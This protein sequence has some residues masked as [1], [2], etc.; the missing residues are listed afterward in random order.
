[1]RRD[2]S[3]IARG[4]EVDARSVG[5]CGERGHTHASHCHFECHPCECCSW[6]AH[7]IV[8]VHHRNKWIDD[9]PVNWM[10]DHT[11]DKPVPLGQRAEQVQYVV[12][13]EVAI[14]GWVELRPLPWTECILV[15]V[16]GK[17]VITRNLLE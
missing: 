11:V 13:P 10:S 12:L 5:Q 3:K 17:G 9:A 2:H 14:K 16:R 6:Y 8:Q 1:M 15:V 7:F 4:A